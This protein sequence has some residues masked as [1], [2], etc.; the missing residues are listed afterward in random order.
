MKKIATECVSW[1]WHDDYAW[2]LESIANFDAL[3]CEKLHVG[4]VAVCRGVPFVALNYRS[5]VPDFCRSINWDKFCLSTENLDT[6]QVLD[7]IATL[8]QKRNGYSARL[9][10]DVLKV[11]N[12]LLDAVPHTVAALRPVRD[13]VVN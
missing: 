4:V 13:D 2:A 12:R 11:R 6:D 5:K 9:R 3:L 1:R 8:T 10:Q 7:S